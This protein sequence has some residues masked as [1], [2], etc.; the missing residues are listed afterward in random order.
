[1]KITQSLYSGVVLSLLSAGLLAGGVAAQASRSAM[2]SDSG[3]I[4]KRATVAVRYPDNE[5]TEVAMN[6]TALAPHIHG[7]AEVKRKEGRTRVKVELKNV[8]HPQTLGAYYTTYVLWAIAPEGQADNLGEFPVTRARKKSIEVT[9]P[10]QTFGLIVTAEPYGLVKMPSPAVVAENLLKEKTKGAVEA[11]KIEYRGDA[12]QFYGVDDAQ[13]A[14]GSVALTTDFTTPLTVLG[15]RRAVMIA[16]RAGAEQYAA[17]E[18]HEAET[19]LTTLETTWPQQK[20]EEKFAGL[21]RDVMR[22]AEQARTLAVDRSEQA[23]LDAERRAAGRAIAQAQNEAAE[24]RAALERRTNELAAARQR[25]AEAQSE[26]ERE[27]ANAEV[28][29]LEA[30][31]AQIESAQA[32]QQA[33]QSKQEAEQAKQQRDEAMQRLYVSL[34]EILETRREARGLIV[35]LSDVLFDFN[36]ATLTAGAREKLSKIAGVLIAYPGA[37]SIEIEGHTDAVGSDEYNLKLSQDRAESVHQYLMQA[38]V[39]HERIAAVRG[40][41]KSQPVASNDTAAGRQQNRRVEIVIHDTA[42]NR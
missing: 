25:A 21:A 29:R 7:E 13:T 3:F 34:S 12:G 19:R 18:L 39:K 26:A 35:N 38:G 33:E 14:A 37:Y 40:L 42:E 22:L 17:A 27:K 20:N 24:T 36:K 28:A 1:M 10:Y 31:R 9:T 15:A 8:E 30:A 41:G 11:S 16:R 4:A 5:G 32:R 6:G 23:R 2:P